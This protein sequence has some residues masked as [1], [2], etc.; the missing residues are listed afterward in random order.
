MF[1]LLTKG[2]IHGKSREDY[3]PPMSYNKS[4]DEPL[5][6]DEQEG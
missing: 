6:V 2:L 1:L 4:I 3:S 5:E